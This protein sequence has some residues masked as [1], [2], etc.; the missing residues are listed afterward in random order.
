MFGQSV[1]FT[2]LYQIIYENAPG[3]VEAYTAS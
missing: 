2:K 3:L 1:V